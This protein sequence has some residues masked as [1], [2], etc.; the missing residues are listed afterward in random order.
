[1]LSPSAVGGAIVGKK[2]VDDQEGRLH[3]RFFGLIEV[4]HWCCQICILVDEENKHVVVFTQPGRN[5]MDTTSLLEVIEILATRAVAQFELV[6]QRCL[7]VAHFP[8]AFCFQPDAAL[9]A[10]AGLFLQVTFQWGENG[11]ASAPRWDVLEPALLRKWI[12][13]YRFSLKEMS[14]N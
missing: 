3:V 9:R 11:H 14:P 6:P 2:E 8:L 10:A 1:M 4:S 12:A 13:P 7:I 5:W